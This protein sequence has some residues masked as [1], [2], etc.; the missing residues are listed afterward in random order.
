[1]ELICLT[2]YNFDSLDSNIRDDPT[3]YKIVGGIEDIVF[4]SCQ[5]NIKP[6]SYINDVNSKLIAWADDE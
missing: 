1:M 2:K 5:I 4:A 6:Q 3:F